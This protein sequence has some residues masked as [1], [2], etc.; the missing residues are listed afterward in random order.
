M[1]SLVGDVIIYGIKPFQNMKTR[2]AFS[3]GSVKDPLWQSYEEGVEKLCSVGGGAVL[4]AG[5]TADLVLLF[6]VR[7]PVCVGSC[8]INRVGRLCVFPL[9]LLVRGSILAYPLANTPAL[10]CHTQCLALGPVW[11]GTWK[12]MEH[13]LLPLGDADLG[14]ENFFHIYT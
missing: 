1:H 9:L 7:L 3:E 10:L 5:V 13:L 12:A 6:P 2:A 11:C 8:F 4:S 14:I